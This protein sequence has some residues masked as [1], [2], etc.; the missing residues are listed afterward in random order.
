MP[1]SLQNPINR[2]FVDSAAALTPPQV[3]AVDESIADTSPSTSPYL[4]KA[5]FPYE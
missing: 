4:R 1:A 5:P 3:S 2:R